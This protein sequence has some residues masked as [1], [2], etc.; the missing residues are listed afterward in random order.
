MVRAEHHA[1]INPSEWRDNA[2]EEVQDIPID[3]GAQ[4]GAVIPWM[5]GL[6]VK[7]LEITEYVIMVG[8]C[9]DYSNLWDA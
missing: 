5:D 6:K 9:S 4:L 3:E 8:M 1:F 2:L 7:S